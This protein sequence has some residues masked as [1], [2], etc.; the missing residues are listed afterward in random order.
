M[1]IS[2]IN[3]LPTSYSFVPAESA[4]IGMV[5]KILVKSNSQ[6]SVSQARALFLFV[7]SRTK[8]LTIRQIQS[9]F[10]NDLQQ[11]SFDLKH[12]TDRSLLLIDEF[13]KGT[14]EH[15][16]YWKFLTNIYI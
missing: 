15:G 12:I 13:G 1:I 7:N 2:Y 16:T 3:T 11:I 5:D 4:E 6:D 8:D 10:M 9:N 14:S